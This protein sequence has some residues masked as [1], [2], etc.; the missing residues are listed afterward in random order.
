MKIIGIICEYNPFHLG[1]ARQLSIVRDA[2]PEC[3][4]V[5]LMSGNFVQRGMPAIID[6]SIRASAAVRCGADLVLELPAQYALSSAEN[7]AQGGVRI[8]SSF[9][10]ALCFGTESG[11]A[12]TLMSTAC[13]LL[14]DDFSRALRPRLDAGLSFPAARQKALAD[15]GLSDQ[16]LI[17]PNDIL[18]VEYCKA[19]VRTG[20]ALTPFPIRRPG[21]YHASIAD[22]ENPSATAVR[23]LMAGSG[24]WHP[25]VP[26]PA[27][28]LFAHA[29]IHTLQAGERAILAKLRS[30]TESDF[31]QLPFGSEGLWRKLMHEARRQPDLEAIAS[32]VKSRR[33]TRT[34]IDRM[35]L[36]AFLGLTQADLDTPAAYTRVLAFNDSGRSILRKARLTGTFVNAG[37]FPDDTARENERRIG[38]LYSLFRADSPGTPGAEAAR[39]IYYHK[40]G[41]L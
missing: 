30:M 28:E 25:F 41:E 19:I 7:F 36:C 23:T 18:G 24:N 3:G 1:H 34:R 35:I 15:L 5:C 31:E 26:E 11:D 22:A 2:F 13:A 14:S 9:C 33:Y 17:S 27:A 16:L 37:E 12:G 21:S 32:A 8:L 20:S 38:D 10:D 39:R 4:I 6:K 40:T 29:P